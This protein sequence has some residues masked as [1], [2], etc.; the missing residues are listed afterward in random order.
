[1]HAKPGISYYEKTLADS[2]WEQDAEENMRNNKRL[3][4]TAQDGTYNLDLPSN[5]FGMS[6]SRRMRLTGHAAHM[7]EDYIQG[8][9]RKT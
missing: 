1:M 2:V 4:K 9:G 5:I 8:C 7:G 6:K 3:E